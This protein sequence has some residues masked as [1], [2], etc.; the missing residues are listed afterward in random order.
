VIVVARDET[1]LWHHLRQSLMGFD[2]VDLVLDRRQGGRLATTQAWADEKPGTDRRR[3]TAVGTGLAR[4][5]VLI[6]QP[7]GCM[8]AT[9]EP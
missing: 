5:S 7:A 4:D 1:D 3:S 2:G 8:P 9:P 6:V